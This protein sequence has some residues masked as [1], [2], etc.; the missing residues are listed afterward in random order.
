MP[1]RVMVYAERSTKMLSRK[2]PLPSM[3]IF[4]PSFSRRLVQAQDV[5][6]LPWTPFCLSS[7]Y[8]GLI[9]LPV[10]LRDDVEDLARDVS[11]EGP[12]CVELGM[13]FGDAPGDIGLCR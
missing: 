9:D 13:S 10:T 12:D 3:E 5:N 1:G 8:A 11:L 4:T 2:R 6:W 7:G